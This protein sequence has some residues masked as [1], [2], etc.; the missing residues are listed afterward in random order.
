MC[1][2]G[3]ISKKSS[4]PNAW[5]SALARPLSSPASF[6]Y[7]CSS[8][9]YSAMGLV[10]L[11]QPE[12]DAA[13]PGWPPAASVPEAWFLVL[14][15]VLSFWSDVIRIGEPSWA[16]VVDRCTATPFTAVCLAKFLLLM[17]PHLSAAECVWVWMGLAVGIGFKVLDY[18][19][20]LG[21]DRALFLASH[22]LWHVSL[23]LL[24]G[25]FQVWRVAQS[26]A[27][28]EC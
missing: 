9:A 10:W 18:R 19:A 1:S 8:F 22:L 4:I 12:C 3:L 28:G 2:G 11:A 21:G 15:G 16:H 7:A 27:R 6:L 24:L 13:L 25:G 20:I 23:P 5:R 14:Q 26:V 17:P